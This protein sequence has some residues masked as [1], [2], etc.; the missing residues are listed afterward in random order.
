MV[1]TSISPRIGSKVI[2]KYGTYL[3]KKK[4]GNGGNGVVFVADIIEGGDSLPQKRDYA[5]KFLNVTPNEEKKL[6]KRKLRFRKEIET[7]CSFQD[8]VSGIIPIYDTSVYCEEEP[9]VLWY[10]MPKAEPYNP[11]KFSVLQKMEQMFDLGNCIRQLHKLD[12]VHRDIK[13]KNLLLFD[14]QLCLS[15]FGLVRNI[16]DIDEH[17][18]EVNEPL[19]PRAIRP[20]EFQLGGEIDGMEYKK[21]DVFFVCKNNLDGA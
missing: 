6:E 13:P 7:V 1:G 15:D 9:D 12:F 11:Q 2:G 8:E 20:P 14:G 5:I 18:T 10:L 4:I 21:S 17:I 16:A 3:V 19:G